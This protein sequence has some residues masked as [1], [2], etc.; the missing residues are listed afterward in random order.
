MR[1]A[2]LRSAA[3]AAFVIAG[4]AAQAESLTLYCSAD[5]AWCQQISDAVSRKRPASPST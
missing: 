3:V 4:G 5:E 2:Y 1:T